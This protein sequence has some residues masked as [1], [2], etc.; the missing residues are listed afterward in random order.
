[1]SVRAACPEAGGPASGVALR[2]L[3][4]LL[5]AS[6]FG[7]TERHTAQLAAH[8]GSWPGLEVSLAAEPAL[9]PAL[10]AAC[11]AGLPV[12]RLLAAAIGWQDGVAPAEN[13]ARQQEAAEALLAAAAPDLVLLPLP[14]PNAGLGL[15]PLLAARRLPRLVVVH[16][17]PDGAAP[18][19]LAEALPRLDAAGAAWAAVAPPGARRAE[20]FFGLPAGRVAVVDNPA[21]PPPAADRALLRHGL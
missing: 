2:R 14:W 8:L 10:R 16:L 4:V 18:P 1:M 12:P 11:P 6:R 15:M 5:P 21:P 20:R 19:G 9:L 17:A 13:A 3:L 7:G